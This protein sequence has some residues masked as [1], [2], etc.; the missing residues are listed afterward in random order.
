MNDLIGGAEILTTAPVVNSQP[1]D[2]SIFARP[3]QKNPQNLEL[4]RNGTGNYES[5]LQLMI[6]L[7]GHKAIQE[8]FGCSG[9]ALPM[10]AF[11]DSLDKQQVGGVAKAGEFIRTQLNYAA[12]ETRAQIESALP[13]GYQT[14][15]RSELPFEPSH[16]QILR[17]ENA[18]KDEKRIKTAVRLLGFPSLQSLAI[19]SITNPDFK[20]VVRKNDKHMPQYL[21]AADIV[22]QKL[23]RRPP[24]QGE[25]IVINLRDIY[26]IVRNSTPEEL[27]KSAF[28]ETLAFAADISSYYFVD[29]SMLPNQAFESGEKILDKYLKVILSAGTRVDLIGFSVREGD[30]KAKTVLQNVL[31]SF[32]GNQW[33][34]RSPMDFMQKG[35][36][37]NGLYKEFIDMLQPTTGEQ[38][39]VLPPRVIITFTECKINPLAAQGQQSGEGPSPSHEISNDYYSDAGHTLWAVLQWITRAANL[40]KGSSYEPL[41]NLMTA[42]RS[43]RFS[44]AKGALRVLDPLIS[45][46]H[47]FFLAQIEW[48]VIETDV[49]TVNRG[50]QSPK[51]FKSYRF[52]PHFD[53][54]PIRDAKILPFNVRSLRKAVQKNGLRMIKRLQDESKGKD[55]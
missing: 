13:I 8:A 11:T 24:G 18:L 40:E 10:V 27:S 36:D 20:I 2:A 12:E 29:S 1:K 6:G 25:D 9:N 52:S 22:S 16:E 50:K 33:G 34:Y 43:D 31:Q 21:R 37:V 15:W 30:A 41:L 19:Q 53:T 55:N 14:I 49:R 47:K 46:P 26:N 4:S 54:V 44:S 23:G 17:I 42:S 51:V 39:Q 38:G 5:N 32:N 35:A 28:L 45:S 3:I 7:L 48:P